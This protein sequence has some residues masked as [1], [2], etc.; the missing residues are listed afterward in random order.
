MKLSIF[1]IFV[2]FT[3]FTLTLLKISINNIV[4]DL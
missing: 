2:V 1:Y 3:Q 4:F